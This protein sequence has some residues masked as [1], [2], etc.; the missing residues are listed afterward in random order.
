MGRREELNDGQ[1]KVRK[2][3]CVRS[4]AKV[5][6]VGVGVK[7]VIDSTFVSAKKGEAA[8]R[9]KNKRG[10]GTLL[11]AV[12]EGVGIPVAIHATSCLAA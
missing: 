4:R 11:M 1:W 12:T 9:E 2:H 10:K 3:S 5:W 7:R 8:P 6:Q